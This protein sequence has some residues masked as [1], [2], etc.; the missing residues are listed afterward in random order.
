MLLEDLHG[1]R[2]AILKHGEIVCRELVY[3]ILMRIRH[4]HI[5]DDERGKGPQGRGRLF[6]GRLPRHYG[7]NAKKQPEEHETSH[8]WACLSNQQAYR[9]TD[10]QRGACHHNPCPAEVS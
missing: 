3:R 1:L 9:T 6:L 4:H 7:W 5:D 10:F 2:P 8:G